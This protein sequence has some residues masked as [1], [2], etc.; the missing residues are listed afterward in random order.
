MAEIPIIWGA[1][2]MKDGAAYIRF[3]KD[4]C[5]PKPAAT[6]NGLSIQM[7]MTRADMIALRDVLTV[8][9]EQ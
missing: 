4:Q 8:A 6:P 1:K 7:D 9:I 3:L 2:V 5:A